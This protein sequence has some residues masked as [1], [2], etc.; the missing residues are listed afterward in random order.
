MGWFSRRKSEHDPAAESLARAVPA[1][2]T[3]VSGRRLTSTAH[4]VSSSSEV[5]A[6]ELDVQRP[7][8]GTTR[9]E[10]QWTVFDVAL[11]DIRPG[12]TLSVTV[13]PERPGIVYPP[14]YPP[15]GPKPGVIPLGSARILPTTQWLDAQLG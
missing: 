10:V 8:S 7:E 1:S 5:Y 13:D 11:P 9:Q 15:V 6:V 3:V 14:G 12:S 2:A 4:G